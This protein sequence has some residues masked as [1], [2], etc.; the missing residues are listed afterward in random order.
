MADRAPTVTISSIAGDTNDPADVNPPAPPWAVLGTTSFTAPATKITAM[1]YQVD[2][3][4]VTS[5]PG[6]FPNWSF[7]LTAADHAL[8]GLYLLTVYAWD[9]N[10]D[11]GIAGKSIRYLSSTVINPPAPG[12]LP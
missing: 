11:A 8:P 9:D 3:G 12:G 1:A 6:P 2:D 7:S 10:N 4:P 5:F